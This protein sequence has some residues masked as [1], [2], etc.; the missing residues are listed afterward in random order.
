MIYRLAKDF[1]VIKAIPGLSHLKDVSEIPTGQMLN[2]IDFHNDQADV[3]D[4]VNRVY[5]K[6][7]QAF[8]KAGGK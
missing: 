8:Y 6:L 5:S 2:Y 4:A 1:H 7:W 3:T